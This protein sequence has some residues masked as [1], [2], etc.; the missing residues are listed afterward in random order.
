MPPSP[1]CTKCS[2]IH[3][4]AHLR[5]RWIPSNSL[6]KRY[7][8][9]PCENV[10][11]VSEHCIPVPH[12]RQ[13]RFTWPGPLNTLDVSY[14]MPDSSG[15]ACAPSLTLSVSL[16]PDFFFYSSLNTRT[17]ERK[18]RR[19]IDPQ[20]LRHSGRGPNTCARFKFSRSNGLGDD[21]QHETKNTLS[22]DIKILI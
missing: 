20:W 7:V 4:K 11:P 10:P 19:T 18:R 14:A 1:G 17:M 15:D 5:T 8:M 9:Y 12:S 13:F 2:P 6:E 16:T 21:I 22:E 3:P